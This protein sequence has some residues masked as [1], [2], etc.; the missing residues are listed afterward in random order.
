MHYK[1][2]NAY[3]IH[4]LGKR[5]DADADQVLQEVYGIGFA[6]FKILLIIE[7]NNGVPQKYIARQ[8]S[9]TEASISRQITIMYNKKLLT[10][11]QAKDGRQN[12][13]HITD[14]GIEMITKSVKLL[15]THNNK[16][17]AN[18]SDKE[19]NKLNQLLKKI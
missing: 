10:I 16:T 1:D 12:L 5:L 13:I 19:L 8:L 4:S 9:Q 2:S 3:M 15:S 17:F 14:R 11:K 6:Q 7:E 18:L